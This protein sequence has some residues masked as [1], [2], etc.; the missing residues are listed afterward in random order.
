MLSKR[1]KKGE[2][3]SGIKLKCYP[4]YKIQ[5]G[6]FRGQSFKWVL[7]NALGYTGWLVDSMRNET[8]QTC[9]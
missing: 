1:S 3:T 8:E 7:E 2:E 5:F 9:I 6:G 4:E